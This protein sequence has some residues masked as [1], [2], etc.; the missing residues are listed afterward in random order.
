M[1]AEMALRGR[2]PV[3]EP[4]RWEAEERE[5]EP[6]VGKGAAGV[7]E[8]KTHSSSSRPL[9]KTSRVWLKVPRPGPGPGAVVMPEAVEGTFIAGRVRGSGEGDWLGARWVE[10]MEWLREERLLDLELRVLRSL[11]GLA[12]NGGGMGGRV[13]SSGKSVSRT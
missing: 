1:E 2:P 4:R 8:V 5:E 7:M 10:A 6:P 13:S 12:P 9:L 11:P 3:E